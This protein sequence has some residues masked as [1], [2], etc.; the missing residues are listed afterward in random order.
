MAWGACLC[1]KPLSPTYSSSP[2]PDIPIYPAQ[3]HT[4]GCTDTHSDDTRRARRERT[5]AGAAEVRRKR[6]YLYAV[7]LS[8]DHPHGAD[9]QLEQDAER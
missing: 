6:P 5:A 2:P 3:D 1:A 8:L 7:S 4:R 9:R